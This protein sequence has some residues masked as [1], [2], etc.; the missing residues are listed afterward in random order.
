MKTTSI[1][2]AAC[3]AVLAMGTAYWIDAREPPRKA[4]YPK[5]T[6]PPPASNVFSE[7]KEPFFD[8]DQVE[9][10]ARDRPAQLQ[11][12]IESALAGGDAQRIEAVFTFLLP[13]LLQLDARRVAAMVDAMDPGHRRDLLRDELARQWIS[14]DPAAAIQWIE[15]LQSESERRAAAK[16]AM[17][18]VAPLDAAMANSLAR[19]FH[20]SRGAESVTAR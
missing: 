3:A 1:A 18:V 11:S 6:P 15:G 13:E 19:R 9:R 12:E 16:Q 10:Y 5:A 14:R 8:P 20:L 17:E 7:S 4:P 2:A